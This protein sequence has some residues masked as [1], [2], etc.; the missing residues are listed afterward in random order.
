LQHNLGG[1]NII[2]LLCKYGEPRV[3]PAADDPVRADE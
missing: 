3:D 1:Y 2:S